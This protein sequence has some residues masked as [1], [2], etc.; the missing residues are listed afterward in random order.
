VRTLYFGT[1]EFAAV[2]LRRLAASPHRP[3]VVVAPPDRP[4]GRG[5]KLAPP[6]VAAAASEIGIEL[7]Q[8]PDVNDRAVA[9]RLLGTGI[10]VGVV[11]A[12]GQIVRE[13]L[14]SGVELLNVHPSLLP[15][16]RGA[17]PIERAIMAGDGTTGV[18]V[19]RLEEGL[20]SGPV[21]MRHEEPIGPGDDYGALAERLAASGGDLLVAALDLRAEGGLDY[22]PQPEEGVTYAEKIEPAE[23]RVDPWAPAR[24]EA[25]RIRAL[26]PH[27]GAFVVLEDESRLGLRDPEPLTAGPAAG[28]FDAVDD[29]LVFGCGEGA[30]RIGSVQPAGGRWMPAGDFLRGRGIPGRA[31]RPPR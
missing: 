10:E 4:R 28:Q 19:M 13:P 2:I 17:A 29:A 24:S 14:L 7:L 16:W 25:L 18:C 5:R 12:F 31:I 20:D 8:P 15:R 11:C 3:A 21:A 27:I 6:P 26:T 9:E 22:V 30:L 1:S 23:R